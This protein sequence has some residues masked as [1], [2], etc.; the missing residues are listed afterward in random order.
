MKSLNSSSSSSS[1]S[2]CSSS[3]EGSDESSPLITS[4]PL[5]YILHRHL[6]YLY[7]SVKGKYFILRLV[8]GVVMGGAYILLGDLRVV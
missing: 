8:V 6:R 7:D 1:S 2:S 3:D 5:S 4:T